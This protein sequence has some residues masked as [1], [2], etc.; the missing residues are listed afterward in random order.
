MA[1]EKKDVDLDSLDA[2]ILREIEPDGRQPMSDLARKL[3]I[4]QTYARQRFHSLLDRKIARIIAI[5]SPVALG[6][7]TQ[8]VT[9][10]QVASLGDLHAV[11]DKLRSL[12]NVKL[13]MISAGWHDIIIWTMFATATDLSTFLATELGNISGIKSTETMMVIESRGSWT[14]LPS[15]LRANVLFA[16]SPPAHLVAGDDREAKDAVLAQKGDQDSDIGIDQLDL[17]ILREMEQDGRQ[18]VSHLAKKLGICRPNARARLQ[19]L[20][21]KQITRIITFT[22][23]AHLGY[24]VFAMIGIKV[25]PKEIDAVMDKMETLSNVYWV[26]RVAGRYDLIATTLFPSLTELSVFLVRELGAI[27][28]VLS[29]EAM[30]ILEVRKWSFAYLASSYLRSVEKYQQKT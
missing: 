2:R 22:N 4:S 1:M 25:S 28:G 3:G 12:T 26:A 6:Y 9:G 19:R 20:L 24:P 7:R 30:I 15:S 16:P 8:A 17:M 23:P 5:T 10:I 27:P 18:P 14:Y 21:D 13:L 11:A 29:A